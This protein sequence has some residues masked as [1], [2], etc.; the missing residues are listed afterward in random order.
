[1]FHRGNRNVSHSGEAAFRR[2]LA[3]ASTLNITVTKANAVTVLDNVSLT[4]QGHSLWYRTS[5]NPHGANTVVPTMKYTITVERD[6]WYLQN[7]A[8]HTRVD[9]QTAEAY[10]PAANQTSAGVRRVV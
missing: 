6:G 3:S 8:P 9:D 4:I 1:M 2:L 7:A 10:A 5:E